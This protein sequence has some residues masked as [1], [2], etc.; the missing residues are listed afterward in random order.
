MTI[1]RST[2]LVNFVASGGSVRQALQNCR[3]LLFGGTMPTG[4][5]NADTGSSGVAPLVTLTP[6]GGAYTPETLPKWRFTMSGSAGSVDSIKIGGVEQLLAAVP[7]TTSLA[8]TASLIAA[9]INTNGAVI[10]F[11][12][13]VTGA[14]S[15]EVA[16]YGP[17]T[18]GAA[19]N[20]LTLEVTST[21]LT[22]TEINA[23]APETAGV[24]C[25]NGGSW[26]YVPSI[27]AVSKEVTAWQGTI[28][29]GGT[30]TWFM[31][32]C[33]NDTGTSSS[34]TAR[35]V[36]GSVGTSGADL[37]LSSVTLVAAATVAVNSWTLSV[38]R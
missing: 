38:T 15:D 37:N 25:V 8:N 6:S 33:D 24:N 14:N 30:A 19:L 11:T 13:V 5:G 17:I 4:T 18:S 26:G 12:A 28:A 1:A 32:V 36:I 22:T 16:I 20:N 34:T 35:R 21:T 9:A 27:G 23:G 7:F 10:D 31:L 3:L 29:T 2:G